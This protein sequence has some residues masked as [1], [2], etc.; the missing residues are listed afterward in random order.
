VKVNSSEYLGSVL[1]A[2]VAEVAVR[3]FTL[4]NLLVFRWCTCLLLL[5][6]L[7]LIALVLTVLRMVILS[8]F[9]ATHGN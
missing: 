3:I 1:L 9:V 5:F 8:Q 4:P 2:A 7:L 6:R